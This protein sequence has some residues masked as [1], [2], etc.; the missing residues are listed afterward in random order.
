MRKL[1]LKFYLAIIGT[2]VLFLVSGAMIWHHFSSPQAAMSGIEATSGLA[3]S[4]LDDAR[5]AERRQEI[6]DSLARQLHADAALYDSAGALL[7]A[8]GETPALTAEEFADTGWLMRHGGPAL[9]WEIGDGRHLVVHPRHRFVW[10]GVHMG[11]LLAAVALILALL[12]YPITR[13]ITARLARLQAGVLQ[14]GAGNLAA[15]VKVEGR[16]EVASLAKSF[17]DSAERIEQ[18]VRAHQLLLANCSH[19]LRTPLARIRLGVDRLPHTDSKVSVEI[20]RSIAELDALIGE[21]LLASRLEVAKGI[22]RAEPVDLLALAAEE[23]AHFDLEV[24][25]D[26]VTIPADPMLLR[27]LVRNLLDNARVH[28]GGASDLRIERNERFARILVE[29]KGA[30]VPETDREK[31]FEPFYRASTA[32]RSSGAGL[33]LSIVKQIARAHGGTVEYAPREG[34]GSRFVVTLPR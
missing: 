33:G 13:G 31:I 27:R 12:T 11:L 22:E 4:M 28:A 23:A 17:N 32:T 8:S 1:H 5:T 20:A 26:A 3:A 21:M 18:L 24:S 2:L 7:Y 30:G 16:D 9:N 19:E 6:I 29:D 10:H 25:G 15:R 34:G 14:F